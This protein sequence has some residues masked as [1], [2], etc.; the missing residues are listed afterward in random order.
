[1]EQHHEK[2]RS[3]DLDDLDL[4][5]H[6]LE[7]GEEFG[8][9]L[10]SDG[11]RKPEREKV[12]ER[13]IDSDLSDATLPEKSDLR[14]ERSP[15]EPREVPQP[16]HRY[17]PPK[18]GRSGIGLNEVATL[19]VAAALSLTLSGKFH[20][21]QAPEPTPTTP[22]PAEV[23]PKSSSIA[24]AAI[25]PVEA[26]P[27]VVEPTPQKKEYK[28]LKV[29]DVVVNPPIKQERYFIL[30]DSYEEPQLGNRIQNLILV[31]NQRVKAIV[32]AQTGKAD[33]QGSSQSSR[34]NRVGQ[35]DPPPNGTYSLG[36]RRG[37]SLA[38]VGTFE[39]VRVFI[40]MYSPSQ[41]RRQALGLHIDTSWG[42]DNGENGTMGCVG[43]RKQD[44]ALVFGFYEEGADAM[45]VFM[46]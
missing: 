44:A 16:E 41:G 13:Y 27:R 28:D 11:F 18:Q 4:S 8:V 37:S 2:F 14:K 26:A 31:E 1:M 6:T 21:S 36:A 38:E 7:L 43:I 12:R 22:Q 34:R 3:H 9:N 32:P 5:E 39:G 15:V 23:K 25:A 29:G 20:S 24:N 33:K 46:S 17:D 35:G 10:S 40:D 30:S 45:L 19:A 42:R